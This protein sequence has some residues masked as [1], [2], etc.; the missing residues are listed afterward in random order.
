MTLSARKLYIQVVTE[1]DALFNTIIVGRIGDVRMCTRQM[2]RD[3]R[4]KNMEVLDQIVTQLVGL[5]MIQLFP[6]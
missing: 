2:T 6:L 1:K 4:T 5:K 3:V